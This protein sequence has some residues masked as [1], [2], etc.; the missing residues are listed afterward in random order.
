MPQ[1][2]V[3][4]SRNKLFVT[5]ITQ[6]RELLYVNCFIIIVIYRCGSTLSNIRWYPSMWFLK[7]SAKLANLGW[8][9][10]TKNRHENHASCRDCM[11]YNNGSLV[12]LQK[13][14]NQKIA[15]VRQCAHIV[16]CL[17]LQQKW[18]NTVLPLTWYYHMVK[19]NGWKKF[20]HRL[21]RTGS[22]SISNQALSESQSW[23]G[24][25]ISLGTVEPPA[26]KK[27]HSS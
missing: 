22:R 21:T 8:K 11:F 10:K 7:S 26:N 13:F 1:N 5:F 6:R 14:L 17:Y 18:R 9:T 25:S 23:A 19:K 3:S 2:Y 15:F 20:I 4:S 27:R 12:V 24:F 16:S